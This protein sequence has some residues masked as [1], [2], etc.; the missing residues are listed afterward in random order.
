M[1]KKG[2]LFLLLVATATAASAEDFRISQGDR[3]SIQVLNQ[4]KMNGFYTVSPDGSFTF[5][6]VGSVPAVGKTLMEVKVLLAEKL[7][8]GYLRAPVVTVSL[9]AHVPPKFFI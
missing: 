1:K 8:S 3:L 2:W 5:P 6:L 7:R 9:D 4:D